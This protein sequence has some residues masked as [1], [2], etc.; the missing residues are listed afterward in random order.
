MQMTAQRFHKS[1]GRLVDIGGRRIR[2]TPA[3][4]QSDRPLIVLEC[5]AFG[6]AADWAVVQEKL[7]AKGLR[8]LAYDRAGLGYSDP[9]PEPRDG[10]AIEERTEQKSILI[11]D[12][13]VW[14][15]FAGINTDNDA[16]MAE[17]AGCRVALIAINF[18]TPGIRHIEYFAVAAEPHAIDKCET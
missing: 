14:L 18:S 3:G 1:R 7:A 8:S 12:Q 4:P 11:D 17:V 16:P 5:G 9:G 15:T 2:A 10:R 13:S 6:C